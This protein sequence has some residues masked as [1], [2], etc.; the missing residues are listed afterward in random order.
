LVSR[1]GIAKQNGMLLRRQHE[2]RI[3][4]DAVAEAWRDR[5]EVE[6]VV[7]FG[8]VAV[9]LWKEVPRFPEYR[10]KGIAVWHEC[11]DVDLAV[12]LS[13]TDQ[14]NGLRKAKA[15]AL[16]RL[17]DETDIGVASHQM[18]VFV[19]EPG[20]DRYLGRLCDFARCPNTKRECMIEGCGATGHLQQHEGFVLS[21][22][23]LAEGRTIPLF[24]RK[25]N[26]IRRAVDVPVIG[27]EE[28]PD[29]GLA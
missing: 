13:R 9:P 1:A 15:R 22:D 11:K 19:I 17:F 7:L 26:L 29:A 8:S 4:A 3:A 12:W 5:P 14:L 16:S 18:D 23:A 10:R 20:S 2:F 28:D 25:T 24:D 27:N 21:P 6:T